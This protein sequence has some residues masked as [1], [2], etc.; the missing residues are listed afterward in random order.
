[1]I[2]KVREEEK[3]RKEA[4]IP[5]E[6]LPPSPS[7]Y[8][9]SLPPPTFLLSLPPILSL[10]LLLPRYDVIYIP[11]WRNVV[12]SSLRGLFT[13]TAIVVYVRPTRVLCFW[14][15]LSCSCSF[16]LSTVLRGQW[17]LNVQRLVLFLYPYFSLFLVIGSFTTFFLMCVDIWHSVINP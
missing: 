8:L 14:R 5:C 4:K 15:S 1:M 3:K 7:S 10:L 16:V 2:R 11:S 12:L 17:G 6:S 9:S 13:C